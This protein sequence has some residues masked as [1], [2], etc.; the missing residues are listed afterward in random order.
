MSYYSWGPL[1]NN[2]IHRLLVSRGISGE[3]PQTKH[4]YL[5]RWRPLNQRNMRSYPQSQPLVYNFVDNTRY[6][7]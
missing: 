1:V 6:C 3:Y 2:V 4:I 7:G 5:S